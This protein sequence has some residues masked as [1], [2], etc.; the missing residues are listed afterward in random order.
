MYFTHGGTQF[1]RPKCEAFTETLEKT[2]WTEV[3]PSKDVR[4]GWDIFRN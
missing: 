4:R 2:L 3:T 1:R